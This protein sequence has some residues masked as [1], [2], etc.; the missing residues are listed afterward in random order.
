MN[1]YISDMHFFHKNVTKAGKNFD[2]RPFETVEEMHRVMKEKWNSRITNGDTVYILGDISMRGTNEELIAYVARLKG[3]KVL[4]KGNHDCV[5]DLRYKNLFEEICD[6]KEIT[7]YIGQDSYR[8]VL[9]HYP[10]LM[11]NGQHRGAIHLYGHT[12]NTDEHTFYQ[13]CLYELNMYNFERIQNECP[14]IARAY[15]VGCMMPYMNYEPRTLKEILD[16]QAEQNNNY[17]EDF[18]NEN[19]S[20]IRGR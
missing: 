16:K 3:K 11:W 6:Y 4:I 7:D 20:I 9:S 17:K 18:I 12:H 1:Y 5:S 8:L 13:K 2:N 15:N 19:S 14:E 10:I